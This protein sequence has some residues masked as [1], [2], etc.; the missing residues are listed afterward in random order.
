MISTM[1]A[2][3]E[4]PLVCSHAAAACGTPARDMK[5]FEQ[6]GAEQD[7]EDHAAGARRLEQPVAH[8]R[9][10]SAAAAPAP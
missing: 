2:I 5:I 9:E 1:I 6:L 8:P 7:Q 4:R 10:A 3:G